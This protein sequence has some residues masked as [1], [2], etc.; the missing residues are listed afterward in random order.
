MGNKQNSRQ[1][2]KPKKLIDIHSDKT[3]IK[4]DL[5]PLWTKLNR[6][7]RELHVG[8][9]TQL[10][11][12]EFMVAT[13]HNFKSGNIN[14]PGFY[15][16]NVIKDE[17][18]LWMEYPKDWW[19]FKQ[20]EIIYDQ[21]RDEL[22]FWQPSEYHGTPKLIII[23]MKTKQFEVKSFKQTQEVNIVN[24]KD[25]IHL[26]GGWKSNSHVKYDKN[27]QNFQ[28]IHK[29]DSFDRLHGTLTA[30]I[31]SKHVI[32]IFGGLT[33]HRD[34]DCHI[35]EFSLKTRKWTEIEYI[36]F[37]YYCGQALVTKDDKHVLLF[38]EQHC[39][40]G[41][42]FIVDILEDGEY[43]LRESGI[44]IVKNTPDRK[45]VLTEGRNDDLLIYG[46]VK[47]VFGENNMMMPSDDIIN[48]INK[49]YDSEILH[50]IRWQYVDMSHNLFVKDH[51]IIHVS[52]V[53]NST[54]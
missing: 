4:S 37:D 41:I 17:W 29:F 21:D 16:F 33:G 1:K 39:K 52:T 42:I 19:N 24:T 9:I 15:I 46:F 40:I 32:L 38:P 54:V 20:H 10:N 6:P 13:N 28:E 14:I 43:E 48:V 3:N 49:F 26:I 12:N 11:A 53:L 23:D 30:Y 35:R 31:P 5:E 27:K 7:L 51:H 25:E 45:L 47:R 22:Y 44:K 34:R 36:N 2:E 8:S 18:K 50:L